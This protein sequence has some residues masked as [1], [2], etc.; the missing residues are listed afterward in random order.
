MNLAEATWTVC[1]A[2]VGAAAAVIGGVLALSEG[3]WAAT[4]L[5]GAAL[6]AAL[7]GLAVAVVQA[8][9]AR[10][11]IKAQA[12]AM[13]CKSPILKVICTPPTGVT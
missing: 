3:A 4:A 11:A 7:G 9:S 1:G 5:L 2:V 6:I 13:Y 12:D 8:R 10:Q